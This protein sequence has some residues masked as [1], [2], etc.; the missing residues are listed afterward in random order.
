MPDPSNFGQNLEK[1][2]DR[3]PVS[4]TGFREFSFGVLAGFR[5][6]T[7]GGVYFLPVSVSLAA[8]NAACAAGF[9]VA[10]NNW[11]ISANLCSVCASPATGRL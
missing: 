7:R 9:E 5:E 4:N 10:L 8:C 3:S 11:F 2:R 1:E 6:D